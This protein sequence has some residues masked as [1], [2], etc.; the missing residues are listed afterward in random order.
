MEKVLHT[1]YMYTPCNT[2]QAIL[3]Y[4]GFPMFEYTYVHSSPQEV[5]MII[6]IIF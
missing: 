3:F 5:R 1:K 2:D 6:T 4:N